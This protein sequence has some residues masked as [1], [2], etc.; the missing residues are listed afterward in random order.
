MHRAPDAPSFDAIE[1]ER[2]KSS[3]SFQAQPLRQELCHGQFEQRFAKSGAKPA[4]NTGAMPMII[5]SD[6]AG[7]MTP[8]R[9]TCSRASC[10]A[11][12]A[13]VTSLPILDVNSC[14]KLDRLTAWAD[15]TVVV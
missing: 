8:A 3:S 6:H 1:I 9:V 15:T 10:S 5:L 4:P 11:P 14:A 13:S 12:G 7:N 2:L